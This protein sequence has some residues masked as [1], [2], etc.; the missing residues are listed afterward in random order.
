MGLM[1]SHSQV[2][3]SFQMGLALME[4]KKRSYKTRGFP[5]S[6]CDKFGFL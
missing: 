1:I 6:S 4:A 5:F 3:L 2:R